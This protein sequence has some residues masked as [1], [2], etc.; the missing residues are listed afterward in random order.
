MVVM[1]NQATAN[2]PL[3]KNWAEMEAGYRELLDARIADPEKWREVMRLNPNMALAVLVATVQS[4]D[5]SYLAILLHNLVESPSMLFSRLE[6]GVNYSE[7]CQFA[8]FSD[9]E[10]VEHFGSRFPAWTVVHE[11]E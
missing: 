4:V 11:A 1:A 7:A 9:E 2:H 6:G 5:V 10:S 3:A 8:V